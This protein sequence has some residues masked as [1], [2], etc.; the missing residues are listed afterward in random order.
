M[1]NLFSSSNLFS[2]KNRPT[3][4]FGRKRT[5]K[6]HESYPMNFITPLST[7]YPMQFP[8]PQLINDNTAKSFENRNILYN[9]EYPHL[10]NAVLSPLS[11]EYIVD[12]LE[13]DN[14]LILVTPSNC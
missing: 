11:L 1:G 7:D 8:N 13:T 4:I 5:K 14:S 6:T 2:C 3:S 10:I 12:P 9:N